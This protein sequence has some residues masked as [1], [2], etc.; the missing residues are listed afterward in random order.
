MIEENE[1]SSQSLDIS[2]FQEQISE[3]LMSK[4]PSIYYAAATVPILL[5]LFS[6]VSEVY[7][8]IE[9]SMLNQAM[10]HR[11]A[12]QWHHRAMKSMSFT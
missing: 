1:N 4:D 8:A 2:P 10:I 7:V 3:W 11:S 9:W 6:L 12:R 5:G